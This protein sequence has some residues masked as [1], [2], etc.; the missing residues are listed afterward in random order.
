M[1]RNSR[2]RV[3]T[4]CKNFEDV[5]CKQNSKNVNT[6]QKFRRLVTIKIRVCTWETQVSKKSL[7]AKW[8]IMLHST[9]KRTLLLIGALYTCRHIR[10]INYTRPCV[11]KI[12]VHVQLLSVNTLSGCTE[13]TDVTWLS[14]L[15]DDGEDG[16]SKGFLSVHER[17]CTAWQTD[18]E[19][20]MFHRHWAAW[21]KKKHVPS[22]NGHIFDGLHSK[23]QLFVKR[24]WIFPLNNGNGYFLKEGRY[25][26]EK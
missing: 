7:C 25:L 26:E 24:N 14:G 23:I 15:P 9:G 11:Q 10:T 22:L 20:F 6:R 3:S 13:Q 18:T 16:E 21:S 5:D 8:C 12:H 2:V 17:T 1:S 19:K 4:L